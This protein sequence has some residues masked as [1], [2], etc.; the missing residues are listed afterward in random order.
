MFPTIESCGAFGETEREILTD[1]DDAVRTAL[2]QLWPKAL[3]V[4]LDHPTLHAAA[5]TIL[6]SVAAD[7]AMA[8]NGVVADT[9]ADCFLTAGKDAM[10]WA[11]IKRDAFSSELENAK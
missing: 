1:F 10:R 4:G 2:M 5:V 6:M 9:T 3:T 7:A 8:V 11:I